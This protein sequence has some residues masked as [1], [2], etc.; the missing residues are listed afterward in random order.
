MKKRTN[1]DKTG[2]NR[3][4]TFYRTLSAYK[5]SFKNDTS[6][7]KNVGHES[8]LSYKIISSLT[9]VNVSLNSLK[10]Y[11]FRSAYWYASLTQGRSS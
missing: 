3:K 10:A 9:I 4:M 5:E 2:F 11:C 7:K 1:R 6:A 8:G